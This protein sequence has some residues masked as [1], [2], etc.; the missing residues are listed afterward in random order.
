MTHTG[1]QNLIVG[2]GPTVL[3]LTLLFG[4]I[5]KKE[6]GGE[7]YIWPIDIEAREIYKKS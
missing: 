1:N 3:V 6:I 7:I 4:Q 2:F 5:R